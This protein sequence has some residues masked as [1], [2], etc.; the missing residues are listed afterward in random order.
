VTEAR[1]GA[2]PA[3]NPLRLLA[4]ALTARIA[5]GGKLALCGILSSQAD[6]VIA[7]YADAFALAPWRIDD[8]W[9]LL[10]GTAR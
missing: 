3:A 2:R 7:A 4:P 6:D 8:G 10:A 1:T 9:T 5:P